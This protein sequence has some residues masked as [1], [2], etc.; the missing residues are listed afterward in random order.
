VSQAVC[1]DVSHDKRSLECRRYDLLLLLGRLHSRRTVTPLLFGGGLHDKCLSSRPAFK[2]RA[3]TS[4]ETA[5]AHRRGTRGAGRCQLERLVTHDVRCRSPENQPGAEGA[6]GEAEDS[7]AEEND[8]SGGQEADR[9][10]AESTVGEG[11]A[12]CLIVTVRR[13]IA[14]NSH[15]AH[16]VS[17]PR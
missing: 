13:E 8:L 14:I 2:K 10:G 4:T 3:R 11:E 17:S 16:P 9:G 7:Q 12:R 15:L 1:L 5:P 6:L